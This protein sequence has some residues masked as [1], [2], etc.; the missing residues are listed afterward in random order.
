M[1]E[2]QGIGQDQRTQKGSTN[3]LDDVYWTKGKKE[4]QKQKELRDSTPQTPRIY[5]ADLSEHVDQDK[6]EK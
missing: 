3:N 2:K 4:T 5:D 6:T 1:N